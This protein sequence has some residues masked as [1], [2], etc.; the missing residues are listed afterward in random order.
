MSFREVRNE[1]PFCRGDRKC[2]VCSGRG[3][4]PNPNEPE[5]RCAGTGV[6]MPCLG[7]GTLPALNPENL[8]Q[9]IVQ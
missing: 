2:S 9:E 8:H 3:R 5:S 7:S 4:N 1:C 6:G